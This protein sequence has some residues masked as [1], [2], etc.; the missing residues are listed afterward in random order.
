MSGLDSYPSKVPWAQRWLTI[1]T[2]RSIRSAVLVVLEVLVLAA[3]GLWTLIGL[4]GHAFKTGWTLSGLLTMLHEPWRGAII[5][6]VF[7]FYRTLRDGLDQVR[8]KSVKTPVG[9]I[10]IH[11]GKLEP[12]E[13]TET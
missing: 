5:L 9:E 12:D 4:F 7:L 6:G 10:E 13:E 3:I 8:F 11:A 1:A 2:A